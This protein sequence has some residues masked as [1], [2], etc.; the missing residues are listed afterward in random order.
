MR[1]EKNDRPGI[2][3]DAGSA[4]QAFEFRA[5]DIDFHKVRRA[6]FV[7]QD[8]AIQSQGSHTEAPFAA[9]CPLQR[10]SDGSKIASPSAEL[11]AASITV[12]F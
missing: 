5:L 10:S 2:L 11:T 1:R 12:Q 8:Q 9:R 6:N 7:S 4:L 3:N